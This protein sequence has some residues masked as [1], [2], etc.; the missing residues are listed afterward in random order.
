M[1]DIAT[2]CTDLAAEQAE[3]DGFLGRLSPDQWS[4]LTPAPGWTVQHQLAHLDFFD[5]AA[6]RAANDPDAFA[7]DLAAA[8]ED[9]DAYHR[10]GLREGLALAPG[11]LLDRWRERRARFQEIFRD[12]DPAT[13]VPWF[14]PPMSVAS[15]VTARLMETWA[16]GQDVVDTLGVDRAP[17]ARLRHVAHIGVRARPYSYLVRD[18]DPPENDVR[19]DL[20][21]PADEHWTWGDPDATDRVAGSALDFC[22]V[23]TRRRHLADTR[24]SVSGEAA[25]EWI[26]IAQSFAGDPGPGREA[27]QF[28]RT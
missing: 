22:L 9:S 14:G 8:N 21:G 26:S 23:V 20:V 3:L 15:K 18:Q 13:R 1:P 6:I 16:H 28:P 7:L 10:E 2:L 12:L 4:T 25:E 19:V 5:G 24:L 11:A 17:T 27:G